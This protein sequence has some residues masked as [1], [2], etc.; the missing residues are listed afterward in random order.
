MSDGSVLCSLIKKL[1]D[2]TAIPTTTSPRLSSDALFSLRRE[3][4]QLP[5]EAESEAALSLAMCWLSQSSGPLSRPL[6]PMKE[7]ATVLVICSVWASPWRVGAALRAL[8]EA[9]QLGNRGW[10]GG[11]FPLSTEGQHITLRV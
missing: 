9:L 2:V 8:P 5:L 1:W 6:S 10:G 3:K 4:S 11:S 7:R